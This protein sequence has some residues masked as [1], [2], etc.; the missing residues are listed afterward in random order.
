MDMPFSNNIDVFPPT[1]KKAQEIFEYQ[2]LNEETL[3]EY[4]PF[5]SSLPSTDVV[6]V[7]RLHPTDRLIQM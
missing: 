4:I 3:L 1:C 2:D 7:D 6:S 5:H